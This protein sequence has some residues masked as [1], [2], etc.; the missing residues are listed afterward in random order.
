MGE[1]R[2]RQQVDN[3]PDGSDDFSMEKHEAMLSDGGLKRGLGFKESL[4]I[5][6]GTI[7]GTGIFMKSGIMSQTVGSPGVVLLAWM[8]C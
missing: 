4:S 6:V 8:V 7:I 1:V 5:V 3:G 2:A